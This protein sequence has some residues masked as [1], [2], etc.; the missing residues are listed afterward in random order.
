[1]AKR[2]QTDIVRRLCSKGTFVTL[3]TR[4]GMVRRFDRRTNECLVQWGA[5]GLIDSLA[6]RGGLSD[7]WL[8]HEGM[9]TDHHFT[10]LRLASETVVVERRS[11]GRRAGGDPS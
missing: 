10:T 8:R 6:G 3:G 4:S 9:A 7:D 5:S 1:M 2:L 11:D